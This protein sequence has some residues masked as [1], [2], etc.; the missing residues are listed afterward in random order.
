[1]TNNSQHIEP[2]IGLTANQV[3]GAKAKPVCEPAAAVFLCGLFCIPCFKDL[4]T[5]A[6]SL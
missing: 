5:I 2:E 6:P 4:D 1:M 3:L